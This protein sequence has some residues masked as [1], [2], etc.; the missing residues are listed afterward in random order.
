M[1]IFGWLWGLLAVAAGALEL[2]ALILR[3]KP[4]RRK[5]ASA[6][7]WW[8]VLGAGKWHALARAVLLVFLAWLGWHFVTGQPWFW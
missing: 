4:R 5:T 7:V 6:Y 3:D 1:T 2:T 8:F